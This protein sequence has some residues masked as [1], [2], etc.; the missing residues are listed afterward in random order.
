MHATEFERKL[1]ELNPRLYLG[2]TITFSHNAEL[3]STGIYYKEYAESFT[4][5]LSG[6]TPLECAQARA[7]ATSP[8]TYIGWC[9]WKYIP[10][11]NWYDAKGHVTAKGL[12]ELILDLS[13]ANYIDRI[14]AN[15]LFG[16][17]AGE[18]SYDNL[19][20]N[21]KFQKY[22]APPKPNLLRKHAIGNIGLDPR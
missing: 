8:D 20:S 10:E 11:G 17:N 3:G 5:D 16:L 6:M 9:T 13:H 21:T 22:W 15:R 2:R 18:S 14:R 12:R 4:P 1:R 7:V 19:S